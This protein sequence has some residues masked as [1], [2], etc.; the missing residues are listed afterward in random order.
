MFFSARLFSPLFTLLFLAAMAGLLPDSA[1][2]IAPT[3]VWK[4]SV[5]AS[6]APNWPSADS[7]C[8]ALYGSSYYASGGGENLKGCY[9]AGVSGSYIGSVSRVALCSSG[10]FNPE[11]GMC[12]VPGCPPGQ[13]LDFDT[14]QCKWPQDDVCS[15]I[16]ASWNN[17]S[18]SCQCPTGKLLVTAGGISRCMSSADDSC[19]KESPDFKGYG[20]TGQ[21]VC[22]GSARCPNGGQPGYVGSGDQMS[23]VC[24]PPVGE[25]EGDDDCN[26]QRGVI[27]GVSVC[28]PKP[29][30]DPDFP[31]CRGVVGTVGGQ[32]VC[33]E[34]ADNDSRCKPGEISGYVGTGDEM[35]HICIPKDY[36]PETCPPGQYIINMESGG[37]GCA[38]ASGDNPGEEPTKNAAGKTPGKV[39]GNSTTE[40]KDGEGNTTESSTSAFDFQIEGLFHDAPENNFKGEMDEF[41]T[42]ALDSTIDVDGVVSE[43]GGSDG[44]FTQRNSLDNA[45]AFIK[46]HT[47]GNSANCSGALN[48]LG[49]NVSCDKFTMYNRIIGW[50]IFVLTAINIYN[51]LMR[52][53]DSG[54]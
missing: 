21:P 13:Y 5:N 45:S 22:D 29:G 43:F 20:P 17:T 24:I 51:T 11:S 12:E 14:N 3:Y 35:R 33:I 40:K 28:I 16:G 49:Y 47:V 4:S 53:S 25:G 23:F 34:P 39:T 30:K 1:F 8:K 7:A 32:K 2:A 9:K 46:T 26:G 36:G 27:D 37:F 41:G 18:G 38:T 54:V 6:T 10:T 48:F 50:M 19:T 44:A 15:T 52:K 31:D 42:A